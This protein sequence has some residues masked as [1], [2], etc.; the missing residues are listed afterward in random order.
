[1]QKA[2]VLHLQVFYEEDPVNLC[3]PYMAKL[4]QTVLIRLEGTLNKC[5]VLFASENIHSSLTGGETQSKI[6]TGFE[7]KVNG[8]IFISLL[9][10]V[11]TA[12]LHKMTDLGRRR[13]TRGCTHLRS[14]WVCTSLSVTG[15][16][17]APGV[18]TAGAGAWL[19]SPG[20]QHALQP[21]EVLS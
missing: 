12:L 19:A 20:C 10:R 3:V 5:H 2:V 8:G 18:L 11:P 7:K 17:P 14:G 4:R 16:L 9:P 15:R 1:M 13:F 6:D 21:A